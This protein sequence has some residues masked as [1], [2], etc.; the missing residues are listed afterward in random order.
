MEIL[1][2]GKYGAYIW[3]SFGITL[4]VLVICVM[5]ARKRHRAVLDDLEA[6][7]KLMESEQ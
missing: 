2:M 1:A 3:S 4:A 5:Q 6:R 7:L